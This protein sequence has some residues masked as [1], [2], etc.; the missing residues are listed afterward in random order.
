MVYVARACIGGGANLVCTVLMLA[1][2]C[3]MRLGRVLGHV[4]HVQLD[5][6]TS[7]NKNLTVIALLAL[8]VHRRYFLQCRLF[9]LHVGHTY[10][11]L[12]QTFSPLITEMLGFVL[13]T[14]SSL[15]AF[16]QSKLAVQRVREVRDLPHLWN[17]DEWLLKHVNLKGGFANTQQSCGMHEMI[18]FLDAEGVVRIKMRQSSQSS[19]W[20]PEGEGE[21]V[22][23]EESPPPDGPPPAQKL[24]ADAVWHRTEVQSNV[25]RWLPYLG[26]A[27]AQLTSAEQ[28]WERVF[29][30]MAAGGGAPD[31]SSGLEWKELPKA[32]IRTG[33]NT[34]IVAAP[35][36]MVE[37]PE[38][39]PIH[40]RRGRTYNVVR[41]ELRALQLQMRNDAA[42][43][44]ATPP[45]FLSEY[46]FFKPRGGAVTALGI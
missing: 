16:L 9:F 19:T 6:T 34:P 22:F 11:D 17:F 18:M 45:I 21:R 14:I 5:N 44:A 24:E 40:C 27:P 1:L 12:D 35:T 37:N 2:F 28:E 7:E 46:V 23:L 32:A 15:L 33:P 8:L 29:A 43:N 10:N 31:V 13:A 20:L 26:L 41:H 42:E 25:R 4:L 3:H 36:D 39:N 30:V 38:V